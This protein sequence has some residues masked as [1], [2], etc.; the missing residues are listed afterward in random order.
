MRYVLV[1]VLLL[2]MSATACSKPAPK[3]IDEL[4]DEDRDVSLT[5]VGEIDGGPGFTAF[6]YAY[7]SAGLKVHALVAVP[8]EPAPEN[9]YPVLI[10]NHG[11]HPEPPKYGITAD[12]K[13]WRP[14]D[15]YRRIPELFAAQGYLVVM[16]DFRG[17]NNSEGFEFTEGMLESS[18]YTEDVLNLLAGLDSLDGADQDNIFMWGHSMGSEV[19]L[20]SLLVTD[21]IKGASM[22]SSIGGDIW[23]QSYYY[24]RY[25]NSLSRDGSDVPKSVIEDLRKDIARLDGEFDPAD[26]EPLNKLDYLR[27]PII[28]HHSIGDRG[29]AYKWSE[30]LAKELY[31]RG[32]PYEFHSYPG[33]DHFFQGDMLQQAVER[34]AGFFRAL[35]L[36]RT[37]M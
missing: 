26:V 4:R 34:D 1:L 12:G 21:R 32:L 33:S 35:R 2:L 28:I 27:T 24:S 37:A 14:G 10:A 22:W 17:H 36:G 11:H 9:G 8:I 20:R 19:T 18:Y 29:A 3:S 15:Y 23:D 5:L 7:V 6:L 13:D 31:V 25:E 30:R 16:P